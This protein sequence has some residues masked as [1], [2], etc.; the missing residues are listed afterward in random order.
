M[1]LHK[2]SSVSV[3]D[4]DGQ[5]VAVRGSNGN[6]EFTGAAGAGFT[7]TGEDLREIVKEFAKKERQPRGPRKPK[8]EATAANGETSGKRS[9]VAAVA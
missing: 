3:I 5:E 2:I 7:L 8:G 4:V 9:K 6:V 1:A